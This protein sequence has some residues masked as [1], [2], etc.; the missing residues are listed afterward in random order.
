MVEENTVKEAH[1]RQKKTRLLLSS[2]PI[3][4]RACV[5]C[6]FGKI[7]EKTSEESQSI[8]QSDRRWVVSVASTERKRSSVR[9]KRD[10]PL[11]K[12]AP[13]PPKLPCD[14]TLSLSPALHFNL[15]DSE[16]YLLKVYFFPI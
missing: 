8:N 6:H 2:S 11:P 13:E 9:K 1:Y 12:L 16:S 15:P 3:S 7:A 14:G 5:R 10:K 4:V